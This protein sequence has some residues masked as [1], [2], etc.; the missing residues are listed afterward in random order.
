MQ[1]E[2]GMFDDEGEAL[3]EAFLGRE[4]EI[5]QLCSIFSR[6][7]P[8][9]P[10]FIFVHGP[11]GTGKT[12]VVKA[13]LQSKSIPFA[14]V[15]CLS[16]H[17]ERLLFECCLAELDESRNEKQDRCVNASSFVSQLRAFLSRRANEER[18]YLVFDEVERLRTVSPQLL[19]FLPRLAEMTSSKIFVVFISPVPW[20]RLLVTNTGCPL[21]LSIFFSTYSKGDILRILGKDC[22]RE[23]RDRPLFMNVAKQLLDVIYHLCNDLAELRWFLHELYP[24]YIA[25]IQRNEIEEE[26]YAALDQ[27]I[28]PELKKV[29]QRLY[30]R[31]DMVDIIA[32][33]LRKKAAFSSSFSSS[34]SITSANEEEDESGLP[35][36]ASYLLIAAF[37]ASRCKT[38]ADMQVFSEQRVKKQRAKAVKRDVERG[39]AQKYEGAAPFSLTKLLS[40]FMAILP[41]SEDARYVHDVYIQITS[42]VRMKFL[43]VSTGP[44]TGWDRRKY[45]CNIS[46]SFAERLAKHLDVPLGKYLPF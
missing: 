14:L 40:I 17:T 37:L 43:G 39:I 27:A 31:D 10:H 33:H 41:N 45:V 36:Y 23:V 4:A 29:L 21:P 19:S 34:S 20:T 28:Q 15:N 6:D 3:C 13:V 11:R 26:D 12:S 9:G 22:P 1:K 16:C 46:L 5:K 25:P 18:V 24:T 32:P 42:L 44:K 35:Y 30:L 2:E 8:T 7:K 38:E